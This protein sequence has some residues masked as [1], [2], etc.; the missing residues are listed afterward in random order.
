MAFV[1]LIVFGLFAM[2]VLYWMIAIY[3]RSVRRERLE[4]EY[5]AEN[6]GNIDQD[7]HDAYVEA[8]MTAYNNSLRPKLIGLVYVVP[9]IVIITIVYVM[10][11]N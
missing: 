3:S 1:R 2:T 4:K 9:T 6:P 8:G 10:N 5:I 7:A 11:A